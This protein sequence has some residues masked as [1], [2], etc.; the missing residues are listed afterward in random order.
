MFEVFVDALLQ[1][2]HVNKRHSKRQK[3]PDHVGQWP[4][5]SWIFLV[6]TSFS[7]NLLRT[8]ERHNIIANKEKLKVLESS[9]H[10]PITRPHAHDQYLLIKTE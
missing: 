5:I 10:R 7:V 8:P 3:S 1:W 9:N 2:N 4:M 6:P